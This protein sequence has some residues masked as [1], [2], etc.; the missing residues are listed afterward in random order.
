M[1]STSVF[2]VI[3]SNLGTLIL[4]L[5]ATTFAV[6]RTFGEVR[7]DIA[8][9]RKDLGKIEGMFVLRL[10]DDHDPK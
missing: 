1:E 7:R 2:I 9:I 3:I 10:R 5:L 6:G 8:E 4:S